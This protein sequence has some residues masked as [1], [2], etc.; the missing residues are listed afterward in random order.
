VR[1]FIFTDLQAGKLPRLGSA[2]ALHAC[3]ALPGLVGRDPWGADDAAGFG[4]ALAMARGAGCMTGCFRTSW[5]CRWPR[6]VRCRSG[7][8]PHSHGSG[9][10]PEHLGVRAAFVGLMALLFASVWYATWTVARRPGVQPADPFGASASRTDVGRAIADLGLLVL[11]A[12]I[13][14]IAR[15]HETTADA[16]QVTWIGLFRSAAPGRSSAP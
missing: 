6:S 15:I 12:T 3:Y 14:L 11:L 16:A 13:G 5:A 7:S 9:L 2:A 1:P 4:I 10:F 8:A